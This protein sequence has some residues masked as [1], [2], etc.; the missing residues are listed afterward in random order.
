MPNIFN[1]SF[2]HHFYL[3]RLDCAILL[4]LNGKKKGK[5]SFYPY[6]VSKGSVLLNVTC[7]ICHSAVISGSDAGIFKWGLLV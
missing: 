5:F 4:T 7:N 2:G 3:R 1:D 6:F